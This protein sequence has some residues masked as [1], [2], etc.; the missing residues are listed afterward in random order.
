MSSLK[1][2]RKKLRYYLDE[3]EKCTFQGRKSD[4][5]PWV[6][7]R[8]NYGRIRTEIQFLSLRLFYLDETIKSDNNG[9]RSMYG[10]D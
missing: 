7:A 10:R 2:V 1:R 6:C 9:R 3:A 4:N 5:T 8:E